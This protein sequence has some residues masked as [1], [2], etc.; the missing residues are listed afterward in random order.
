TLGVNIKRKT[1]KR[2]SEQVNLILWDLAGGDDYNQSTSGY[3]KGATGILMV[4]DLTRKISMDAFTIYMRQINELSLDP[5]IV[6][7]ANK[8]DLKEHI[9][10]KEE[11]LASKAT[12]FSVP[13]LLSSA[14]TG[15]GVEE[16]FQL[17]LDQIENKFG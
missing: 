4:C 17:L 15:E 7:V 13:Y 16:A 11:M 8:A 3:L 12:E 5:A 9:E 2:D 6:F 10:I 14:K 1:V